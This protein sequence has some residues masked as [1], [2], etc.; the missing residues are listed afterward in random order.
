MIAA[1]VFDFDGLILDTETPIF[2]SWAEAYT[3]CGISPLTVPEWAS[4]IGTVGGLDPLAELQRRVGRPV[5]E[6]VVTRR[7]SRRDALLAGEVVRPGVEAWLAAAERLGL[8]LAVASSSPRAWVTGHLDRLGLLARFGALACFGDT[9]GDVGGG[10]EAESGAV[11]PH[12][13]GADGPVL[14]AGLRPKPAPDVYLAACSKLGVQPAAALA[15]EDSPN[16]IRA[17]KAAGMRCVAVP[18][19]ITRLLDLDAAD[20]VV[21]SLADVTISEVLATLRS[22]R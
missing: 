5:L 13:G 19:P 18:N 20:L 2:Q 11:A 9:T 21:G 15:V 7:R 12:D 17:A 1:V 22:E 16:G 6:E 10:G 3:E 14:P 4:A 8:A